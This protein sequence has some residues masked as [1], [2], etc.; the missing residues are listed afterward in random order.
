MRLNEIK[1]NAGATRPRKRVGRGQGSGTGK[2]CGSGQKGQ[3]ARTGVAINGFE[4]GQNS[5]FK[6]LP[7][8]G[9]TNIFRTDVTAINVGRLQQY[10]DSGKLDAKQDV[11]REVLQNLGLAKSGSLIK[12]LAKGEL[13]AALKI[14]AD[15]ASPSA[16]KA[17]EAAKGSVKLP[18]AQQ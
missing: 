10:V 4:G 11:T 7:K 2:T 14:E 9:F 18:E 15:R 17:V 13:K 8:R 6:R 1:N 5:I 12:I 16:V 3:K